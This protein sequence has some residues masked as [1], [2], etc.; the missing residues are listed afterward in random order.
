MGG[1]QES[2]TQRVN[3]PYTVITDIEAASLAL[4]C[5]IPTIHYWI[6]QGKLA[7]EGK[8]GRRTLINLQHAAELARKRRARLGL[9]Q[10]KQNSHN[11]EAVEELHPKAET[12]S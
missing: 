2:T 10:P 4:D 8:Q 3:H 11:K 12:H 1:N 9:D 5:P 6:Q 7:R